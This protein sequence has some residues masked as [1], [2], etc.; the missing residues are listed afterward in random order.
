MDVPFCKTM[1]P[2]QSF[3]NPVQNF[4]YNLVESS[5][6]QLDFV[7]T[8]LELNSLNTTLHCANNV[9]GIDFVQVAN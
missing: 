3:I 7:H 9:D 5:L 1:F 8:Q 2:S 6:I 4:V